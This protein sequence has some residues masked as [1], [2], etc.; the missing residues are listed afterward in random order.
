MSN[1]KDL[2]RL[3]GSKKNNSIEEIVCLHDMQAYIF[4]QIIATRRAVKL[5]TNA[6]GYNI[7]ERDGRNNNL[8]LCLE[9]A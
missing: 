4:C 5:K 3:F 9:D 1:K 8:R 2:A 7:S 6:H